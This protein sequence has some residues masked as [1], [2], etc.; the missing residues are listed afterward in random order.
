MSTNN[1]P[2]PVIIN[3]SS[4][5]PQPVL[6]T[7]NETFRAHNLSWVGHLTYKFG[8]ATHF[9]QQ[10]VADGA[11]MVVV[12]GGDGTV[13]EVANG[14]MGSE[15]PIGILPGGTGNAVATELGISRKIEEAAEL[16]CTSKN[17]RAVDIAQVDD[18]YYLLRLYTG[19]SKDQAASR[20][21]KDKYHLMAYP[22]EVIKVLKNSPHAQ[23]TVTVDGKKTEVAAMTCFV[24]NLDNLG[25]VDIDVGDI[26]PDDGLVDVMLVSKNRQA[27]HQLGHY[28][29]RHK[30]TET[31]AYH[32][33]GKVV[34]VE[35]DPPQ[36]VWLDGEFYRNTPV[37][38]KV[39]PG[40]VKIIVPS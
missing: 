1:K 15:V 31:H 16:I 13:L 40:A 21:L 29:L 20:E 12:Y 10:A 3:P 39:H 4:G 26:T 27:L 37:T 9:A 6:H 33:Q 19:V 17:Q 25:G 5:K 24:N 11:D 18:Q 30:D 23:Y 36:T 38:I 8:D 34:T 28:V 35:A 7:V 14:V 32:G 2:I 22:M